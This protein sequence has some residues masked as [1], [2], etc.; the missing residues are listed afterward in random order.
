MDDTRCLQFFR[1][2]SDTLHRRYELLRAFFVERI[3]AAQIAE[4]FGYRTATVYA[5]VRDFRA[6]G[7][8]DHIPPFSFRPRADGPPVPRD[9]RRNEPTRGPSHARRASR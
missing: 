6:Q 2:P 5:L 8:A 4:Q 1:Q 9:Q 3:P 7:Q